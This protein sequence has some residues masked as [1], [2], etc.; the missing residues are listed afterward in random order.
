MFAL[1]AAIV[2]AIGVVLSLMKV[3]VPGWVLYLVLFFI[4]MAMLVGTWPLGGVIT[5]TG[6][7]GS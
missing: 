7:R 6:R 4:A 2:S 5:R 3:A 1:G